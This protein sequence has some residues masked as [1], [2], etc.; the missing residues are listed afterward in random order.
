MPGSGKLRPDLAC[1][2]AV[3]TLSLPT[4]PDSLFDMAAT[5][6]AAGHVVLDAGCR[7][8]HGVMHE[9]PYPDSYFDFV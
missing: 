4:G 6:V 3:V 1:S 2:A 5:Y 7:L 9:L 8:H